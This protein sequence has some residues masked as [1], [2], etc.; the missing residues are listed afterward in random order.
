[1]HHCKLSADL[2][3]I[4]PDT[5]VI[6]A[7]F[8]AAGPKLFCC[9][10]PYKFRIALAC[11]DTL[12]HCHK[13]AECLVRFPVMIPG[14]LP[15]QL[16]AQ[17]VYFR[18]D[19]L[20]PVSGYPVKLQ[21]HLLKIVKLCCDR[22]AQLL[23]VPYPPFHSLQPVSG[24]GRHKAWM[25]TPLPVFKVIASRKRV[26]SDFAFLRQIPAVDHHKSTP[27]QMLLGTQNIEHLFVACLRR[28][29]FPVKLSRRI[30][31]VR[32]HACCPEFILHRQGAAHGR[33]QIIN[34]VLK[35]PPHLFF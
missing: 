11:V 18:P 24:P 30:R 2:I 1:M 22:S 12:F 32:I 4:L 29:N 20:R 15:R 16:A 17:A 10:V 14:K 21:T 28:E 3:Q 7:H 25:K 13:P 5:S 23:S 26:L 8:F 33:V 9:L 31:T 35:R 27:A 34:I 6:S 19:L